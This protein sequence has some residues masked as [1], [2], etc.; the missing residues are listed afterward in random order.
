M[1]DES[2]SAGKLFVNEILTSRGMQAVNRL[3]SRSFSVNILSM[4]ALELMQAIET[5]EDHR[6]MMAARQEQYDGASKQTHR[7]A[8]RLV[9]NY[10]CAVSTFIDHSRNFMKEHYGKTSFHSDYDTVIQRRFNSSEHARFV[11]D[12]RN[13]LTIEDFLTQRWN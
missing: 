10:L 4:N 8:N 9:H 7:E 1:T 5:T 11:R 3:H 2:M 6:I 13:Y 12:L